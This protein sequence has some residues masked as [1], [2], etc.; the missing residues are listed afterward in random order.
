M[1]QHDMHDKVQL[2]FWPNAHAHSS[3]TWPWWAFIRSV[4]TKDEVVTVAVG[5]GA[6]SLATMRGP[7]L[8]VHRDGGG[9]EI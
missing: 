5:S 3:Y 2:V 9:R 4:V 8:Y 7:G 1:Q 6:H